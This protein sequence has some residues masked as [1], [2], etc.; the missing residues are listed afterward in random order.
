MNQYPGPNSMLILDNAKIHHGGEWG[1]YH[2]RT[3]WM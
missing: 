1:L 3:R 2:W